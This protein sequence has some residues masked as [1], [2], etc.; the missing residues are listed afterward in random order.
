[1][2]KAHADV[3]Y[4]AGGVLLVLGMAVAR[5]GRSCSHWFRIHLALELAA[6]MFTV[7]AF[8]LTEVWHQAF[9]S[10]HDRHAFNGFAFAVLLFGQVLLGAL[11]PAVESKRRRVWLWAHRSVAVLLLASFL[12]QVFTGFRRLH[13]MFDPHVQPLEVTFGVFVG[14]AALALVALEVATWVRQHRPDTLVARAWRRVDWRALVLLAG[15]LLAFAVTFWALVATAPGYGNW[16]TDSGGMAPMN[17][18]NMSMASWLFWDA[19]AM[20]FVL[21]FKHFVVQGAARTVCASVLVFVLALVASLATVRLAD[22]R[23]WDAAAERTGLRNALRSLAHG[24][25]YALHYLLMLAVMTYSVPLF[26]SIIAGHTTGYWVACM[27]VSSASRKAP[28][29]PNY[30][31]SEMNS[32]PSGVTCNACATNEATAVEPTAVPVGHGVAGGRGLCNCD[33]M[34]CECDPKKCNHSGGCKC[35]V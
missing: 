29:P 17:S 25:W 22:T 11:R 14:V 27:A 9:L 20:G 31:A 4:A 7:L 8:V 15:I 28:L 16:I 13:R 1:M 24:A 26:L 30:T 32:I 21:W 10:M 33:P 23:L 2:M 19:G 34:Q 6:L 5:Y 12:L 35:S 3:G 18:G